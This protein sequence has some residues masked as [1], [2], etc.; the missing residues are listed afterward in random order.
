[1]ISIYC[2]GASK[3]NPGPASIGV[4]AVQEGKE[5]FTISEALGN[6]TNNFAE[7]TS[8]IQALKKSIENKFLDV[9]IFMDSELVVRQFNGVYKTKHPDLIPLKQEAMKLAAQFHSIKL[10]HIPREKNKNADTLA[11][12]ALQ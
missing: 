8:L 3:G 12:K 2:D 5:V 1:M 6:G 9:E 11:N 10:T 7:W 4:Y